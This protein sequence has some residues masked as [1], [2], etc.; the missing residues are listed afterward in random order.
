[1]SYYNIGQILKLVHKKNRKTSA[2]ISG[3]YMILET[4]VTIALLGVLLCKFCN[5]N[6]M[7]DI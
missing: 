6:K 1:M 2:C 3:L 7:I 4:T 5:R